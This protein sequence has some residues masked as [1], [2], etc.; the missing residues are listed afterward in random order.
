MKNEITLCQRKV[1][2]VSETASRLVS[3]PANWVKEHGRPEVVF[4]AVGNILIISDDS[5][6]VQRAADTLIDQGIMLPIEKTKF[7]LVLA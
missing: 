3:L 4:M 1:Y 2:G 5:D 7:S 6:L